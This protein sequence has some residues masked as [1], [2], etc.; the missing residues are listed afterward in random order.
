MSSSLSGAPSLAGS[1]SGGSGGDGEKRGGGPG[2]GRK[3]VRP[4]LPASPLSFPLARRTSTLHHSP[5]GALPRPPPADPLPSLRPVQSLLGDLPNPVANKG[6]RASAELDALFEDGAAAAKR[7]AP[8]PAAGSWGSGGAKPAKGGGFGSSSSLQDLG[9]PSEPS[10]EVILSPESSG[11]GHVETELSVSSA[12]SA[13]V[14]DAKTEVSPTTAK[15]KSFFADDSPGEKAKPAGGD[16]LDVFGG[17]STRPAFGA[18]AGRRASGASATNPFADAPEAAGAAPAEETPV[19]TFVTAQSGASAALDSPPMFRTNPG[20][21]SWQDS[22]MVSSSGPASLELSPSRS[23][24]SDE[25]EMEEGLLPDGSSAQAPAQRAPPKSPAKDVPA[26]PAQSILSESSE[27]MNSPA[28][29]PS[30]DR[31]PK[32]AGALAPDPSPAQKKMPAAAARQATPTSSVKPPTGTASVKSTPREGA[33]TDRSGG[34]LTD[35]SMAGSA[36][37]ATPR[38]FV[39]GTPDITPRTM[40]Y[41]A[42]QAVV[43]EKHRTEVQLLKSSHQVALQQAEAQL[44]A[45]NRKC[46]QLEAEK[47]GLAQRLDRETAELRAENAALRQQVGERQPPPNPGPDRAY[48]KHMEGQLEDLKGKMERARKSHDAHVKE[49]AARH[50]E[51]VEY[52]KQRHA[53]EAEARPAAPGSPAGDPLSDLAAKVERAV[54]SALDLDQRL[55]SNYNQT[56]SDRTEHV[57]ELEKRASARE[58]ALMKR[59]SEI[60]TVGT[61]LETMVAEFKKAWADENQKILSEQARMRQEQNRL[62]NLANSLNLERQNVLNQISMERKQLE[63]AKRNATYLKTSALAESLEDRKVSAQDKDAAFEA[64]K[65]ALSEESAARQ[66]V[67][68]LQAR[69]AQETAE[70][71]KVEANAALLRKAVADEQKALVAAQETLEAERLAMQQEA[72]RIAQIGLELQLKSEKCAEALEDSVRQKAQAE[73]IHA[74]I[75]L[76]KQELVLQKEEV[77]AKMTLFTKLQ[78]EVEK[79]KLQSAREKQLLHEERVRASRT[80]EQARVAELKL[81]S[82][83]RVY[84]AEGIVINPGLGEDRNAGNVDRRGGGRG[85]K[86]KSKTKKLLSQLLREEKSWQTQRQAAGDALKDQQQFLA[87]AVF[88]TSFTRVAEPRARAPALDLNFGRGAGGAAGPV[89]GGRYGSEPGGLSLRDDDEG[90]VSDAP[91]GPTELEGQLQAQF[92]SDTSALDTTPYESSDA[93]AESN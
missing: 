9:L 28:Y 55:S 25:W 70:F 5:Q 45:S 37:T 90:D 26:S 31:R 24:Y 39:S 6:V 43:Q 71:T 20:G 13:D 19:S 12:R 72:A 83:M 7:P 93:A 67:N 91:A 3:G 50:E 56:L 33:L 4:V 36:I 58:T 48:V 8:K 16:S 62:D 87:D 42:E 85:P 69:I 29:K 52:L 81:Q 73:E 59:E 22:G 79:D 92:P 78:T 32:R 10:E 35:R 77:D 66:R 27:E 34:A 76:E 11:A 84:A 82:Q 88:K 47:Q 63:D 46:A 57:L 86:S 38:S 89:D 68:E 75:A 51:Q 80:A 64:L 65:N 54:S 30:F 60:A 18:R 53:R 14:S 49:M 23:G 1:G 44:Q 40:E 2:G 21:K 15:L 41:A 17:G 74:K 61:N